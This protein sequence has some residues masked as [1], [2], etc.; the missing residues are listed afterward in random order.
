MSVWLIPFFPL[1]ASIVNGTI[2]SR[3]GKKAVGMIGC[4]SV[5]LS[6]LV[7][8]AAFFH[9]LSLPP[10]ARSKVDVLFN[11]IA[12][13]S[14]NIDF[15]ILI[16]PLSILMALVVTGVG[17]LIH[18]YSIGYM[19]E[20]RAYWRYF[21]YLN[22]FVFFMSMLVLSAD[23]I[24][25]YLGWEGVGLC[26]YLLIGFWYEKKSASDAGK[27]A[28]IVNRVGDF[29]FILGL[30]LL[31]WSLA[32][33][34]VYSLR[35][36]DVFQNI[37]RI[38]ASALTAITLLLFAGAVGKSAQFPL[39]V[40]LPDAMEG[41]TPVS[42]LIHA[43][44]MVTAGVYM[45]ARSSVLFTLAPF[46]GEVI[47]AIGIFTALFAATIGL[48]QNDIKRVLA[49]STISQLGFMFA[50]VGVGAYAAGIFHL[51]T[52]A[53]F[54]GLLFLGAG[55][56][57]H[58]MSG[59]QDMR[60]MGGLYS[61][62]KTTSTTFIIG[63]VA[64]AGIPPLSGFWSKDEILWEAFKNGHHLIWA[65]GL[66]TAFL[67]AFYMF[68][69]VFTVFS[70][71]CRA[72]AHIRQ[73]LHESPKS[74]TL[75]LVAL[76]VLAFCGGTVGIPFFKGGS[77]FHHYL[78]PVFA[79]G[80]HSPISAQGAS[81]PGHPGLEVI[82]MG[83]SSTAALLGIVLAA[84]MYFEPWARHAPLFL[85]PAGISKRFGAIYRLLGNKYYIDEIYGASIVDPVKRL[86]RY[87]LSFDLSFI[88]GLVDGSG[89]LTRFVAWV[90]HKIDIYLV[91][92]AINSMATLVN[93]NSGFWRR[94]QTGYLQ[95]YALMFV[96]GLILFFG[97]MLLV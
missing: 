47:A 34:G 75:P 9:L 4:A 52:H 42:A 48:V 51:M 8:A 27:K 45:V 63:A 14:F 79:G 39:H 74:M 5:G 41:P 81:Q 72:D 95:N 86:S 12:S 58:G 29:G 68:R 71:R 44:T 10:E 30:F 49:Y 38:D 76:A 32:A 22:L 23:Y 88:D 55:S 7:S 20:D 84:L 78:M 33:E 18:V 93:F 26:S 25:L 54:K 92:G 56:V 35:Y 59:E 96:L 28:F 91:D 89:W 19:H 82:L 80:I 60:N 21:S 31:F 46:T 15:S 57:I 36:A 61:H 6:M 16:D 77:P 97:G 66:F 40:W 62:M 3:M 2:G 69:Q 1:L 65:V 67:T 17:F 90:S 85:S 73:H 37:H 87:C 24:V 53:F 83:V 70:G 13:G 50:A 11:W 43:A 64:I 94:L